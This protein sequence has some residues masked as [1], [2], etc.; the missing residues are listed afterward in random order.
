MKRI[1]LAAGMA[2]LGG[3][4]GSAEAHVAGSW[5]AGLGEGFL[6]PIGGL[7]H[8]L[9]MTALGLWAA[10]M[11]GRAVWALP[12]AFL[13]MMAAGG[14][15]GGAGV[16]MPW[17]EA[18]VAASVII[19]G[20]AAAFAP[21]WPVIAGLALA[22]FFALQHGHAHGTELPQAAAPALFASGFLAATAL[23]HGAGIALGR[24]ARSHRLGARVARGAGAAVAA[25][26]FLLWLGA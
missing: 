25:A 11:G 15:L 16:P 1:A 6:H 19:F 3:S 7:D 20:A 14:W 4:A 2:I 10:R 17:V 13:A 18:G 26:G 9:A 23:L 21:R 24:W 12:L 22:G 5:G 8:L